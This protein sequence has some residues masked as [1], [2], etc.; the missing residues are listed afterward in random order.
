MTV[1]EL[2]RLQDGPLRTV[3]IMGTGLMGTSLGQA[4]TIAGYRVLLR[5]TTARIEAAAAARGAGE[6]WGPGTP[7]PDLVVVAVPPAVAGECAVAALDEFPKAV[8]TDIAS[9]KRPVIEQVAA[10]PGARRFLG[11]HPMAGREVTGPAG[12][13]PDLFR[14]RPWVLCTEADADPEVVRVVNTMVSAVGA[15]PVRLSAADH[16]RAVALTSHAPQVMASLLAGRL[17]NA[18]PSEVQV[19]GQGLRDSIRIAGS[20][21]DLWAGILAANRDEVSEVLAAIHDELGELVRGL[22]SGQESAHDCA[23]AVIAGG[24]VGAAR[25][26]GKHGVPGPSYRQVRVAVPDEPGALAR[27][28]G[29]VSG[30]GLNLED[31]RIEHAFGRPTGLVE[32]MVAAD[33]ADTLRTTLQEQGWS[34]RS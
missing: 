15:I 1:A 32:L 2:R 24:R 6:V 12:A 14:D 20:D 9:V 18:A 22:R 3:L 19:S 7:D 27:L 8:V 13:V 30:A 26:P 21:P 16:D 28:L 23:R 4:L 10:A 11:G 34:L 25:L 5:D 29:T 31:V 17:A 33:Q